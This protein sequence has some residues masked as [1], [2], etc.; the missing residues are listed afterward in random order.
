LIIGFA[1]LRQLGFRVPV[2]E[3]LSN[4]GRMAV[5]IEFLSEYKVVAQ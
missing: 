2:D 5:S 3:A 1:Y 4:G